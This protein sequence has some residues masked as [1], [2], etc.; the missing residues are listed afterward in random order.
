MS[1]V[2]LGL[3]GTTGLICMWGV[4]GADGSSWTM[5]GLEV[6]GVVSF[7]RLRLRLSDR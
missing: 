1:G 2:W 7:S 3:G 4:G 5:V 6:S